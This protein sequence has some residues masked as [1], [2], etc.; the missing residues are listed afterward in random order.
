MLGAHPGLYCI[1]ILQC[2]AM[3]ALYLKTR[4]NK[5]VVLPFTITFTCFQ[6]YDSLAKTGTYFLTLDQANQAGIMYHSKSNFLGFELGASKYYGYT[7]L[8][9]RYMAVGKLKLETSVACY[10]TYR[11]FDSYK[12]A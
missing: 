1:F 12:A 2:F 10:V 4:L 5:I 9:L 6:F 7:G 8:T 11:C 3:I